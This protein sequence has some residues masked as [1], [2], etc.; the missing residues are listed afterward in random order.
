M[1]T[2]PDG[3]TDVTSTPVRMSAPASRAARSSSAVTAPMPPTGTSQCPVS[4]PMTWYRK[5]RFCAREASSADANVPMSP[6]VSATPRAM[7]LCSDA[8]SRSPSGRSVSAVQSSSSPTR[9]RISSAVGS[10]SVIVGNT[11][12][13]SGARRSP[14]AANLSASPV[15][16]SVRA[17]EAAVAAASWVSIRMPR[18]GSDGSG[19]YE[20]YLRRRRSMRSPRS[21]M[22]FCGS[23]LTRYEYRD[24]RA[25]TP[26]HGRSDTAAPPTASCLSRITT[27]RP[28]RAR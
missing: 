13:P 14:K 4:P 25:S 9:S 24:S 22:I 15:S 6:S 18:V 8:R 5:Q 27:D 2:S 28:A 1:C 26:G 11:A 3:E 21:S 12:R 7:S 10:G 19:V 20:E 16:P 23:R 17:N